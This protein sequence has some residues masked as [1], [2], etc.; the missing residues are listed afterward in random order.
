MT[1]LLLFLA[2]SLPAAL[3]ATFIGNMAFHVTD[4]RAT[5]LSDF[6][7]RSGYSGYMTYRMEDVPPLR[8]ALCLIT[9]GH[10]DHF[11]PALAVR[12]DVRLIAP[13]TLAAEGARLTRVPFAPRMRVGEIEVEASAVAPDR[14]LS[15]GGGRVGAGRARPDRAAPG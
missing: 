5:L 6:P 7:Y 9:H 3:E 15:P 13:P 12:L 2:A 10:P 14:R 11:E 1:A 4:G 8:D